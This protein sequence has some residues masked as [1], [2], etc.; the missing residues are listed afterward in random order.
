MGSREIPVQPQSEI[1]LM[2]WWSG[3]CYDTDFQ[4]C[5]ENQERTQA[6][7]GGTKRK[8]ATLGPLAWRLQPQLLPSHLGRHNIIDTSVSA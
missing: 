8:N 4:A 2:V 1:D 3:T 5:A 6:L 7:D